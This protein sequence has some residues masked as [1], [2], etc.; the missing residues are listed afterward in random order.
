[1]GEKTNKGGRRRYDAE[2]KTKALELLSD[3]RSVGSVAKSLGISQG[4]LYN[5]KSQ[6][7]KKNKSPDAES[8]ALEVKQLKKRL[9]E[10]E[11]ERDILKKALSIF[12]RAT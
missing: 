4:V 1:M 2:F 10:L 6:A 8:S 12:S 9:K 3:G 11:L 7:N 5:W